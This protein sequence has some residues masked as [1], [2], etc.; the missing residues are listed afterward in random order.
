M[1]Y[2]RAS[3]SKTPGWQLAL[4][5]LGLPGVLL[6]LAPAMAAVTI[7]KCSEEI[8]IDSDDLGAN[9][10]ESTTEFKNVVITG[11]DARIEARVARASS[12]DFE[13]ASWTFDGNVRISMTGESPGSLRSDKAVVNFRENRIQV[14]TINGSPAEFEQKR[15]NATT[16]RGRA[17]QMVYQLDAGTVSLIDDASLSDD[18]GTN[19]KASQLTYDIR[20]Q[21]VKA[22]GQRAG[23]RV[24]LTIPGKATK[25]E[26]RPAQPPAA[27]DSA[28]AGAQTAPRAQ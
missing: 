8:Q 17:R 19:V 6:L 23:E 9:F 12:F 22:S 1:A 2:F 24:K 11:C 5:V 18:A 10:R 21:D 27:P 3:P 20:T 7:E 26:K 16:M 4:G 13:D 15:K 28:G 25:N 14:V